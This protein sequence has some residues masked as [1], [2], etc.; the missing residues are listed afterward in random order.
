MQSIAQ[1]KIKAVQ[2]IRQTREREDLKPSPAE[3]VRSLVT[4]CADPVE[5][6]ELYYWSREPALTE[7]IRAFIA[8]SE[9]TRREL[10]QFFLA[11]QD[12]QA[13]S[14]TRQSGA[15]TLAAA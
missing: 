3:I 6:L 10:E 9:P 4:D 12:P 13:V 7:L 14:A 1:P 8:L 15:I 11:T 5:I 2:G